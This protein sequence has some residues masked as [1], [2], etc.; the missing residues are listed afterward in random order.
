MF[1]FDVGRLPPR[2]AKPFTRAHRVERSD[3]RE[4][5]AWSEAIYASP[6]RGAKRFTRAHRVE[7]SDL[8]EPTAWSEAIYASPHFNRPVQRTSD[9][10]PRL[11]HD[12]RINLRGA[13]ILMSEQ[14]LHRANVRSSFQQMRGK[15]CRNTCGV[16]R[17]SNR[18]R[19]AACRMAFWNVASNT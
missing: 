10:Q 2:G 18:A 1:M 17:L 15:T 16:T 4:T 12:M 7:R 5:T 19:R 6:P 13:H 9:S 8:R 3:L 14:I 11:L